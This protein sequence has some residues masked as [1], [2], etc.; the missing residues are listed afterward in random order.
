MYCLILKYYF[1]NYSDCS[2]PEKEKIL[3]I[4]VTLNFLCTDLY[5]VV[6]EDWLE[7]LFCAQFHPS[8][9]CRVIRSILIILL[10]LKFAP[11]TSPAY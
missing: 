6:L 11:N 10:W 8:S 2:K 7:T 1:L 9:Y 3:F 5:Q 4:C